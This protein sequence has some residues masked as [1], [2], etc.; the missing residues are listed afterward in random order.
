MGSCMV[1][2]QI[3]Q[4]EGIECTEGSRV[5]TSPNYTSHQAQHFQIKQKNN[6][7]FFFQDIY[8]LENF[9]PGKAY[10]LLLKIFFFS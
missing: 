7:F 5:F 6:T 9:F 3:L 2:V 10:A 1:G 8:L 4:R